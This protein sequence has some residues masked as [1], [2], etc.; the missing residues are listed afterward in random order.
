M[1]MGCYGS[2]IPGTQKKR[3]GKRQNVQ[4]LENPRVAS[5]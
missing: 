5:F 1:V 3:F 2:K 4:N